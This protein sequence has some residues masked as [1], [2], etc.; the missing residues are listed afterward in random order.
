LDG[1]KTVEGQWSVEEM[2]GAPSGKRVLVQRASKNEFNVIVA[3]G[4]PYSDVDVSVRFKPISGKE[5]ASGGIVFRF[6]DGKYYVVRANAL[7]DNFRFYYYDKRRVQLASAAVKPPA[8]G[9][10]HTLRVVAVSDLV[11]AYLDGKLLL[12]HHDSRFRS[13]QVGLW[14]KTDSV[15]AFDDL[16]VKGYPTK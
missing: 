6:A 10:W 1:W 4:G 13:G 11:Q 14:T 5:D 2:A 15:T 7:E 3:P 9:Q 12:N 16:E 8:L